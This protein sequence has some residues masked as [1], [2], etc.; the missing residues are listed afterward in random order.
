MN[1][2]ALKYFMH[3]TFKIEENLIDLRFKKLPRVFF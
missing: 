2:I 1:L 3:F